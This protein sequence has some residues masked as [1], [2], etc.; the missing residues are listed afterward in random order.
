MNDMFITLPVVRSDEKE[1]WHMTLLTESVIQIC[2]E[3][4]H[5]SLSLMEDYYNGKLIQTRV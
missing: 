3:E 5:I 4:G 2:Y 1:D